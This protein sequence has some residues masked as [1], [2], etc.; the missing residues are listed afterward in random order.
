MNSL[1][2][3]YHFR[4]KAIFIW[5]QFDGVV[6]NHFYMNSSHFFHH[7]YLKIVTQKLYPYLHTLFKKE[8]KKEKK[9]KNTKL[10]W[11]L[12]IFFLLNWLLSFLFYYMQIDFFNMYHLES[13]IKYW[14]TKLN[15][16]A[17][18]PLNAWRLGGN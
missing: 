13:Y 16:Q 12:H 2:M 4:K 11:L 10:A 17:S 6:D 8:R 1:Y 15:C 18:I 9:K 3:K 5:A 14:C 7:N